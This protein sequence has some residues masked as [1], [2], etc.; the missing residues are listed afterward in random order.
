[1]VYTTEMM[2]D[3]DSCL[4]GTIKRTIIV[5]NV[6][7]VA[8]IKVLTKQGYSWVD[9]GMVICISGYQFTVTDQYGNLML[10]AEPPEHYRSR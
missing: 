7:N 10:K 3:D 2:I 9:I 1:M 8:T 6:T 4:D 5:D